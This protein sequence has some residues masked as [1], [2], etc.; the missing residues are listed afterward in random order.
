MGGTTIIGAH[1][2]AD[3]RHSLMAQLTSGI[4][5]LASSLLGQEKALGWRT[6]VTE[7]ACIAVVFSLVRGWQMLNE[8]FTRAYLGVVILFLVTQALFQFRH[9]RSRRRDASR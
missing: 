5:R 9:D 6:I 3:G 7:V 4:K 2:S 8:P 1:A